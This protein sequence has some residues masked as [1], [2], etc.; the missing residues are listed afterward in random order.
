[1]ILGLK[2]DQ[3]LLLYLSLVIFVLVLDLVVIIGGGGGLIVC[4]NL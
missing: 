1:M 3:V 4:M 2:P